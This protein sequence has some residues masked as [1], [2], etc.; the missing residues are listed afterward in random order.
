M[1]GS[2]N[3][4]GRCALLRKTEPVNKRVSLSEMDAGKNPIDCFIMTSFSDA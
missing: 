3:E 1:G 4:E 2:V